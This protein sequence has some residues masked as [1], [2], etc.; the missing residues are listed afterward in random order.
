MVITE[1]NKKHYLCIRSIPGLFRGS[2]YDRG[3]FYCNRCYSSF[4]TEKELNKKYLSI[5]SYDEEKSLKVLRREDKND[6]IK[7]KD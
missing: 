1:G 6:I 2:L 4:R 7:F 3:M 5:C